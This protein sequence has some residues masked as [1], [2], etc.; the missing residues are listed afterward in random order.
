[1]KEIIEKSL[2]KAMSYDDY[3]VLVDKLIKEGK[4]T[5]ENQSEDLLNY[6]VLNDKRMKRLDK[7]LHVSSESIENV[8]KIKDKQTWLVL[9]EGWCG[10]A[11]QNLPMINKIAKEN[12][13]INLQLVLRDENLDLMDSFLTNGGRSIPKLIVLDDKKNVVGTWGPRPSEATAMVKTYKEKNGKLDAE[14]KKDLQIWYNK[15]KG[16]NTEDDLVSLLS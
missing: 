3:K 14:F 2:S 13:N 8:K 10:D 16:R 9:T 11:A 1:M 6:S 5:G 7:T 12:S 15:N 4:S